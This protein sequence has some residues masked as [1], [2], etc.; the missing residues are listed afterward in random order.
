[1]SA[2]WAVRRS[3]K[4]SKRVNRNEQC[5]RSKGA[6]RRLRLRASISGREA[7]RTAGDRPGEAD[8]PLRGGRSAITKR[9]V[10][11]EAAQSVTAARPP[12]E[13]LVASD[14]ASRRGRAVGDAKCSRTADPEQSDPYPEAVDPG[15]KQAGASLCFREGSPWRAA[16]ALRGGRGLFRC[17][18]QHQTATGGGP[19]RRNSAS[20]PAPARETGRRCPAAQHRAQRRWLGRTGATDGGDKRKQAGRIRRATDAPGTRPGSVRDVDAEGAPG[21]H[22]GQY[23]PYAAGRGRPRKAG[24]HGRFSADAGGERS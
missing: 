8:E 3:R 20:G 11:T 22:G 15:R 7:K 1:M 9:R 13:E 18:V 21:P 5:A 16:Q 23:G 24:P 14:G 17:I 4:R 19:K 12:A 6:E 2:R 10:S